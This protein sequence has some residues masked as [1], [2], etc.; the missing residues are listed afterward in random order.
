MRR[1]I[2]QAMQI[3]YVPMRGLVASDNKAFIA[4]LEPILIRNMIIE[5]AHV[6]ITELTGIWSVGWTYSKY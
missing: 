1:T 3:I 6:N 5:K 4:T 2:T